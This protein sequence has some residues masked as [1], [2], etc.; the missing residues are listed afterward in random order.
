MRDEYEAESRADADA[1]QKEEQRREKSREIRAEAPRHKAAEAQRR[2]GTK[3]KTGRVL[4][5]GEKKEI[6][7]LA[8]TSLECAP[9][10]V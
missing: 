3:P 7:T 5:G 8:A 1:K 9:I 2:R 4:C 6:E 10:R